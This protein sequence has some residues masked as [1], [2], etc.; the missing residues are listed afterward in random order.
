MAV[1]GE[2]PFTPKGTDKEVTFKVTRGDYAPLMKLLAD[3][4]AKAKVRHS[5]LMTVSIVAYVPSEKAYLPKG[6]KMA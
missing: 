3:N 4:L 6:L 2:Y 1:L 5:F